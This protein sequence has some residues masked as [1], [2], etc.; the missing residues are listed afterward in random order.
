MYRLGLPGHSL[1]G[2]AALLAAAAL[3]DLREGPRP[4]AP[5]AALAALLEERGTR[6]RAVAFAPPPVSTAAAAAPRHR[7]T[8]ES[9]CVGDD[10]VPTLSLASVR[11]LLEGLDAID[12]ELDVRERLAVLES[13]RRST[14][15]PGY[16]QP[17]LP[18]PNRTRFP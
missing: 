12:G 14:A 13:I 2:G 3:D 1:G 5:G 4:G 18:R 11:A 6:V 7:L 16:L 8:L 17:P 10:A 9:Y 15:G